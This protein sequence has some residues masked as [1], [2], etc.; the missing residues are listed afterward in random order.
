MSLAIEQRP[1]SKSQMNS[2]TLVDLT[3]EEEEEEE[4]RGG[5]QE[6]EIIYLPDEIIDIPDESDGSD[7]EE[8]EEEFS[9]SLP[10]TNP[11][12]NSL[13]KLRRPHKKPERLTLDFRSDSRFRE[14]DDEVVPYNQRNLSRK[15]TRERDRQRERLRRR[16]EELLGGRETDLE[17]SFPPLPSFPSSSSSRL[18]LIEELSCPPPLEETLATHHNLLQTSRLYPLQVSLHGPLH[19]SPYPATSSEEFYAL[20]RPFLHTSHPPSNRRPLHLALPSSLGL[21]PLPSLLDCQLAGGGLPV[22]VAFP[23]LLLSPSRWVVGF[24]FSLDRRQDGLLVAYLNQQEILCERRQ[25]WE[26]SV[27]L[28]EESDWSTIALL[29]EARE[30]PTPHLLTHPSPSL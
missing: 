8:E 2:L 7:Q 15:R 21:L 1:N 10:T 22:K 6:H 11:L 23:S 18:A 20:P 12:E 9:E 19:P 5:R 4:G 25:P 26:L 14:G 30:R 29:E 16:H 27:C 24:V 28:V 17:K 13:P 3:G